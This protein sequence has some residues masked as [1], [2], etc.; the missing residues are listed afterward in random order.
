MAEEAVGMVRFPN[1]SLTAVMPAYNEARNVEATI[2]RAVATLRQLVGRFEILLI[3]DHSRDE[4][5]ALVDALAAELPEVRALHNEV[6]LRQ[7]GSLRR[8]FAEARYDLVTHNAVD[9]PFDFADLPSLL[10]HFPRADVVVAGRRD[11]PGITR[12]RRFVSDVN[13]AILRTLFGCRV[14]DYNFVQVYKRELV[15]DP[16]AFSTATPFITPELILRAH[17]AGRTVVEVDVDY[18]PRTVGKSSSFNGK[19]VRDAL[20]DMGRLWLELRLGDALGKVARA[21]T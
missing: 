5:P 9:Y 18:H 10:Q 20:R 12:G 8:G 16:R 7:G 2:R 14:R 4:T 21:R 6:N 19:N 11:Y 17:H 3:D 13:R 1:L 15:Q